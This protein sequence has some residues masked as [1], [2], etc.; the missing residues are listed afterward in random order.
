MNDEN[1]TLAA[2]I[3]K[4]PSKAELIDIFRDDGFVVS[5]GR[6]SVILAD[7]D[8]FAFRELGGDLGTGC[9]TADHPSIEEL[10][11]FSGRVSQ[12]LAKS[13]IRHR[14]EVYSEK[15]DLAAYFHHD[16]PKDW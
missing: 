4:W 9:V 7:F 12:T 11:T 5:E 10:V 13:G 14:F 2:E 15:E 6:Y 3:T 16:W 1:A 8:H